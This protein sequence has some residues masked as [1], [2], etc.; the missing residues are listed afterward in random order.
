MKYIA[1]RD[2]KKIRANLE[3]I[4]NLKDI[5]LETIRIFVEDL[6]MEAF[7]E[8]TNNLAGYKRILAGIDEYEP[9]VEGE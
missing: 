5:D 2:L 9:Y 1:K 7:I 8:D 4:F 3:D 6:G